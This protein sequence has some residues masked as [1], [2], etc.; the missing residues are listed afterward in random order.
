[1]TSVLI[2]AAAGIVLAATAGL[3]AFMPLFAAG[4]AART[5]GW[6][7][8]SSMHWL[9]STPAL[10]GL[11]VATV[12]EIVADKVPVV[13]HVLDAIHTFL[14]PLAGALAALSV[15]V[16]VPPP[17]AM[18]LA[19]MVGAPIAGGVHVLAAATRL[20]STLTTGGTMNPV[21]STVEDGVSIG[22]I[23]ITLLAPVLTTILALII[24]IIV[25][26]FVS[27]RLTRA[28]NPAGS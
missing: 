17:V 27:R 4:V 11:G 8:S 16:H 7:L 24:L 6:E 28:Q 3:R 1:M 21:A 23:L 20:K 25:G 2:A 15:W 19:I 12:V 10:V 14:G 22:S 26:R 5:L 9:A 13:D 18:A